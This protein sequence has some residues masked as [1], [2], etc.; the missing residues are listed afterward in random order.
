MFVSQGAIAVYDSTIRVE[1]AAFF[2]GNRAIDGA[3]GG[4]YCAVSV[5]SFIGSFFTENEAVW[6]GGWCRLV[7]WP[8]GVLHA[9]AIQCSGSSDHRTH[10]QNC[11]TAQNP[12][13]RGGVARVGKSFMELQATKC[14]T[15]RRY[16]KAP[17][18][19][20]YIRNMENYS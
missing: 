4:V 14:P 11:V 6:G 12:S 9:V 8:M 16:L 13:A 7:C 1:P 2:G 10:A 3:G 5:A 19:D 18:A 20:S 17:E 15:F